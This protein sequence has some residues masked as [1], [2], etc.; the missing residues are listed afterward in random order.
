MY[1]TNERAIADEAAAAGQIDSKAG[2]SL[3]REE[4][5]R[6]SESAQQLDSTLGRLLAGTSTAALSFG[7]QGAGYLDE[8][9]GQA[10]RPP[11]R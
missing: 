7:G 6:A 11:R 9:S 4:S 1:G 2:T 5:R 8:L 3:G 10:Q